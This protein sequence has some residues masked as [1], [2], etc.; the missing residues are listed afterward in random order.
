[1]PEQDR[2]ALTLEEAKRRLRAGTWLALDA[3]P[4]RREGQFLNLNFHNGS[5]WM[6]DIDFWGG[7]L[8]GRAWLLSDLCN[9]SALQERAAELSRS[10]WPLADVP[11]L[12]TGFAIYYGCCIGYALTGD[13]TLKNVALRAAESVASLYDDD[14]GLVLTKPGGP[15]DPRLIAFYKRFC[16]SEVLVDTGA[17]LDLLWW[18]SRYEPRYAKLAS[19]HFRRCLDL[20]LV[21]VDGGAHHALDFDE[22]GLP[23]SFHTHQGHTRTSRWTRGQAWAALSHVTAYQATGNPAFRDVAVRCI[24]WYLAKLKGRIVPRYDLEISDDEQAPE[25]SCTPTIVSVAIL[26]LRACD[27]GVPGHFDRYVQLVNDEFVRNY[28]TPGGLLLHGSWGAKEG[29]ARESVMPYGNYFLVE[30]VYRQLKPDGRPWG[31]G[32]A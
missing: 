29:P 3:L 23:G 2:S 24:D 13:E 1:M 22:R 31:I 18:A 15:V 9:D 25:D 17:V 20:G 11:N 14:L 12:D 32:G 26:R 28:L 5:W 30:S 6:G 21:D 4:F 10:L 16:A 7:F 19:R 27:G 8:V